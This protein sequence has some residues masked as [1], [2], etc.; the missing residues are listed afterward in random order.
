MWRRF[1]E[2]VADDAVVERKS[3]V[4]QPLR[5]WSHADA[6][7]HH[8]CLDSRAVR[9]RD[10]GH[11]RLTVNIGD[12]DPGAKVY[13]V[14]AV[15]GPDHLAECRP[16]GWRERYRERLDHGDLQTASAAGGRDLEADEPGSDDGDTGRVCQFRPKCDCVVQTAQDEQASPWRDARKGPDAR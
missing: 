9:E 10:A 11:V 12:S 3:T 14:V 13:P 5:V 6:H 8:I 15:H 7:Q 4:P 1:T 16:Q 2:A